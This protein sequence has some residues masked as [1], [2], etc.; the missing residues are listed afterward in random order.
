MTSD[1]R[2]A[3]RKSA[4]EV[5]FNILKDHGHLF[6]QPFWSNVFNSM[7]FPVFHSTFDSKV[8]QKDDCSSPSARFRHSDGSA[9]DSET[10]AIA[11]QCLSDLFVHFFD[12]VRSQLLGVVMILVGFIRSPGQGPSSAGVAALMRLVADLRSNLFENEWRDIFLC[13]KEAAASSFPGLLKLLKTMD[14]VE[15]PDVAPPKNDMELASGNGA[16][17]DDPE[18]DNL[19]T[20]AYVVSRMKS[21]ITMQLL[22][23]QVSRIPFFC[24]CSTAR[25]GL[26]SNYLLLHIT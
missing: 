12:S 9:W 23:L 17:N 6:S 8:D 13:L 15:V 22:I 19:Q 5:L 2:S 26:I 16:V 3:I 25:T 4:L 10:S 7:I 21:H 1:P 24:M 20:A 18:D 14:S 11:A